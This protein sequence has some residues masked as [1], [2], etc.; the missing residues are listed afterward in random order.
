MVRPN[1]MI[2]K[3][4]RILRVIQNEPDW[5]TADYLSQKVKMTTGSVASRLRILK[6]YGKVEYR[7]GRLCGEWKAN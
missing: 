5:V 6:A 4:M 2:P 3:S 7:K 1:H